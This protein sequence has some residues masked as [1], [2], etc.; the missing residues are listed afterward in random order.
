MLS[1]K[2]FENPYIHD[3]NGRNLVNPEQIYKIVDSH[4]QSQFKDGSVEELEPCE[5]NPRKLNSP[6]DDSAKDGRSLFLYT[7]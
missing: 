7:I 3:E 6:I 2:K 5:G 1:T 4:F